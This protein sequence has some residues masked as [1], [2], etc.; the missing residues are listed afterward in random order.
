MTPVRI[1]RDEVQSDEVIDVEF[2]AARLEH[3]GYDLTITNSIV[4]D[5]G[6]NWMCK[7]DDHNNELHFQGVAPSLRTALLRVLSVAI[8]YEDKKRNQG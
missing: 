2:V 7:L 5:C 4:S 6:D 1:I 8:S 3:H